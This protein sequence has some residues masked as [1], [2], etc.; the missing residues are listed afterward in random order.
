M[1]ELYKRLL[2][3][4]SLIKAIVPKIKEGQMNPSIKMPKAPEAPKGASSM[5]PKLPNIK[6]ANTSSKLPG[7]MPA[8]AKDPKKVAQQLKNKSVKPSTSM[9]M[10][11]FEDNGQWNLVKKKDESTIKL[12]NSPTSLA[13]LNTVNPTIHGWGYGHSSP[14]QDKLMHGIQMSGGKPIGDGI[15][16]AIKTKSTSHSDPIYLKNAS[17]HPDREA[18]G[19]NDLDSA[20][21]EVL[22]HNLARDFFNMG[23]Y[24]PTTSGF[25]H[26]GHNYSAQKAVPHA[27]HVELT[28]G[29]VANPKHA[30]L[31]SKLH[32]SGEMHKLSIMDNLMGHHDRHHHNYL[33]DKNGN[34][35]HLIDN[36]TAFDYKNFDT[37]DTPHFHRLATSDT[38][39]KHIGRKDDSKLHPEALKWL[40]N[41]DEK[42]AAEIFANHS[43]P[44]DAEHVKGFQTRLRALKKAANEG[45][46]KDVKSL[47]TQNR[48]SSGPMY[49]HKKKE[50][51]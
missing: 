25:Q 24:V 17:L 32:D 42:K 35:L 28:N 9:E 1:D 2:K 39:R 22:Y 10:I 5:M 18:R 41:L 4:N 47:L 8:S 34:N 30:K 23:K 46:Y 37:H 48:L 43:Y 7:L 15:A 6:T 21:R 36:G 27:S 16:S 40:N 45:K 44:Q 49:N 29:E 11:K 12:E 51:A 14:E 33:I 50:A 26:E 31:L 20:H 13:H 19:H 38:H 3:I